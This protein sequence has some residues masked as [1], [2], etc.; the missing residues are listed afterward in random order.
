M[1]FHV[2]RAA[3]AT[4]DAADATDFFTPRLDSAPHPQRAGRRRTHGDGGW[5]LASRDRAPADGLA[6]DH[7]M[8]DWTHW[9]Y[10]K[11]LCLNRVVQL[12]MLQGVV[13]IVVTI[14]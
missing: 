10:Y 11:G 2:P 14:F 12:E 13:A 5:S 3:N 9:M 1:T 6:H 7:L 4:A 8:S